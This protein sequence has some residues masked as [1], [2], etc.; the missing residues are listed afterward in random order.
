M[1][2]GLHGTVPPAPQVEWSPEKCLFI[3]HSVIITQHPRGEVWVGKDHSHEVHSLS[4]TN[5]TTTPGKEQS[6]N[7]FFN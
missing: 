2:H 1:S 5:K 7:A 4:V 3:N 6:D